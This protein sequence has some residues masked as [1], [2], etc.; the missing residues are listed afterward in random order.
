MVYDANFPYGN[1]YG[2]Y[3]PRPQLN[4]YAFVN[5]VEGAKSY[6]VQPNQTVLLMDAEQPIC[7]MK[8]ANGL[9]QSTLRYFKLV[10]TNENDIRSAVSQNVAPSVDYATKNDIADIIKRLDALE[11]KKDE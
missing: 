9:G 2:S 6:I 10:E 5:G 3:Q 7:Y 1:P 4:T 11:G 8:Q